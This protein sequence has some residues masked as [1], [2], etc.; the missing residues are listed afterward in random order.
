MPLYDLFEPP[1]RDYRPYSG[2][3]SSWAN[4]IAFELNRSVLPDGFVAIAEVRPGGNIEIDTAVLNG[5]GVGGANGNDRGGWRVPEPVRASVVDLRDL[6]VFEIRVIREDGSMTLV[7]AVELA[8][9][10]NKD[11][12]ASRRAFAN[13]CAAYLQQGVCVVIIDVVTKKRADLYK[14]V[15]EKVETSDEP[16]WVSRSGLYAVTLRPI[17][18]VDSSRLE[19]WP[20]ELVIGSSLP[21][22]PLWIDIDRYVPLDLEITFTATMKSLR[23]DSLFPRSG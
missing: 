9:P 18:N 12:P 4:S 3:H 10:S 1:I 11:R 21:C 17:A 20:Y 8:S 14:E 5:R 23:I 13:K 2:I 6:D 15:L 7:A 16:E 19:R 22:L